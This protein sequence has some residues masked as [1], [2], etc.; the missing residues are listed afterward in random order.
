M[1]FWPVVCVLRGILRTCRI[2]SMCS[3]VDRVAALS[4]VCSGP[5][6]ERRLPNESIQYL[7]TVHAHEGC[8]SAKAGES[9]VPANLQ[10]ICM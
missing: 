1:H 10:L 5:A 6:A 9:H 2:C 4:C 3:G 7:S 8:R